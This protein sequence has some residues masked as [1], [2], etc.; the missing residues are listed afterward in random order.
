MR[1]GRN[2][3][4][5]TTTEWVKDLLVVPMTQRE[6][7]EATGLGTHAIQSALTRLLENGRVQR[8]GP[9]GSSR[10]VASDRQ[11]PRM[12]LG[13]VHG[14]VTAYDEPATDSAPALSPSWPA[15]RFPALPFG[16][17]LVAATQIMEALQC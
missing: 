6:L 12:P 13:M 4:H 3:P 16:R 10:Y 9:H 11:P 17:P 5:S 14:L 15:P 8:I 2:G 7:R 1:A